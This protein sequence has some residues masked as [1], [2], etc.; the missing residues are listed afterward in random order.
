MDISDF[1]ALVLSVLCGYSTSL[2][3]F[4][5]KKETSLHRPVLI[6]Q[7]TVNPSASYIQSYQCL[8]PVSQLGQNAQLLCWLIHHGLWRG[9]GGGGGTFWLH[10][11]SLTFKSRTAY[12][13]TAFYR[14]EVN[15]IPPNFDTLFA[16]SL[17][18]IQQF[19]GLTTRRL[20]KLFGFKGLDL[21]F[22]TKNTLH[23]TMPRQ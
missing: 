11:G 10:K 12:Q 1:W 5:V 15:K 2:T 20:Y 9:L 8:N 21:E 3:T 17:W 19:K 14:I 6:F 13:A 23:E 16:M 22:E 4:L 7:P 18:A